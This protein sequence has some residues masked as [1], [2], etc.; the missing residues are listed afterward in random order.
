MYFSIVFNR[1]TNIFAKRQWR[2]E[3]LSVYFRLSIACQLLLFFLGVFSGDQEL[4]NVQLWV[5]CLSMS[6]FIP[7]NHRRERAGQI[8]ST[9]PFICII[10]KPQSRNIYC[11]TRWHL[12]TTTILISK[13]RLGG[14]FTNRHYTIGSVC[15]TVISIGEHV[16]QEVLK[17]SE[18]AYVLNTV[19][20]HLY[21]LCNHGTILKA[22]HSFKKKFFLHLARIPRFHA[23]F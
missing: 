6:L 10:T 15:C 16:E 11:C 8:S 1:N 22:G 20:R 4:K 17:P 5:K 14:A 21:P 19:H 18:A 2:D 13:I 12:W 7:S 23:L 3:A 9:I